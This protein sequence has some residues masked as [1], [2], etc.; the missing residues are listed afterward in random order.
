[1]DFVSCLTIDT[2]R[3]KHEPMLGSCSPS[4]WYVGDTALCLKYI[5]NKYFTKRI[6][7]NPKKILMSWKYRFCFKCTKVSFQLISQMTNQSSVLPIYLL[8]LV[9]YMAEIQVGMNSCMGAGVPSCC[10][11]VP[12][13]IMTCSCMNVNKS[14]RWHSYNQSLWYIEV[15]G[16]LVYCQSCKSILYDEV[17][18]H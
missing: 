15:S 10:Q 16:H 17:H 9:V 4:L 18:V 13:C 1:M 8:H 3:S 11:H 14:T 12:C 5:Y 6:Y 2:T 7:F